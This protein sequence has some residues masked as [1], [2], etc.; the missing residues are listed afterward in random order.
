MNNSEFKNKLQELIGKDSTLRPFVC[1]GYP[2]E[3]DIFI[4][5]INPATSSETK[6]FDYWDGDKFNKSKWFE[7]YQNERAARGKRKS[8]PTRTKIE[9]LAETFNKSGFKCMETNVYK[10]A[11][12]GVKDLTKGD[13]NT[14]VLSFLLKTIK[15]KALFVHGKEAEKFIMKE[16]D[17]HKIPDSNPFVHDGKFGKLAICI[18]KHLLYEKKQKIESCAEELMTLIKK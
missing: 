11:T 1:E 15:P 17:I 8:S 12:P 9:S 3:C 5:G 6:F 14:D 13:K 7:Q 10:F 18:T 16:L 4:I 2:L